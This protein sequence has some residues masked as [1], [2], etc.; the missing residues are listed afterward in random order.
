MAA[1]QARHLPSA[2][3]AERQRPQF[4]AA[5]ALQQG[6]QRGFLLGRDKGDGFGRRQ[7][8]AVGAV[9]SGEPELGFD[10]F[11]CVTP[12]A[13]EQEALLRGVANIY[14]DGPQAFA[15]KASSA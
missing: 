1:V 15:G 4:D 5:F 9:V 12:V 11:I 7:A 6:A 13:G 14:R 3:I 8:Q 2:E 10:A